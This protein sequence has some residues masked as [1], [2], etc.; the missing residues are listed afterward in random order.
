MKGGIHRKVSFRVPPGSAA[1]LRLVPDFEDFDE[2]KEVLKML[3]AGFGLKDA[4]RAWSLV[5]E[6]ALWDFGLRPLNTDAKLFVKHDRGQLVL[7]TSAHVDDLKV[8]AGERQHAELLAHLESRFGTMK[9]ADGKFDHVG[10]RHEDVPG[11]IRL[12]QDHYVSTLRCV[13]LDAVKHFP[14]DEEATSEF[15]GYFRTLLGAVAWCLLTMPA[16]CVYVAYLQRHMQK[17]HWRQ[18]QELNRLVRWMQ[19]VPQGLVFLQNSGSCQLV[20]A[21]DSLFPAGDTKG[22]VMR[23]AV[24]MLTYGEIGKHNRCSWSTAFPGNS[25]MCVDQRLPRNFTP[26][27]TESIR[28]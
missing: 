7:L 25:L 23:G 6:A 12:H 9:Q 26:C 14:A 24:I 20:A 8:A 27:W 1:L 21:T 28:V 4:P 18:L 10:I 16:A 2:R 3:A 19:R 17:S 22:L 13:C 5:L 15:H 11:G